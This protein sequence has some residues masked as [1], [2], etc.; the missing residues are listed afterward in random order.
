MSTNA[1]KA[2]G[3]MS[4]WWGLGLRGLTLAAAV[5][6]LVRGVHWHDMTDT[7]RQAGFLLPS[8]VI[9][10]NVG[11]MSLRALR[12]RILLER[13]LS[14][15]S[16]FVALL[17][18]SAINNITPFRGGNVARLWMLER[19]SGVTKSAAIAVTVVENL[20]EVSVLAAMGFAA[21]L[22]V[23]GQRWATLATPAVFAAAVALL[24]LLRFTAENAVDAVRAAYPTVRT[25]WRQRLHQFLLRTAPGFRALSQPGVPAR[26]L[27]LSLLAWTCETAMIVLVARAMGLQVSTPLA[28]VVLL[29]INLAMALPSTPASAGPFE[30]ATVAVLMLAGVGK[31]PALAFAL[32]YHAIQV[33]PVTVAGVAVLLL[34]KRRH[35]RFLPR[36]PALRP[37]GRPSSENARR[38][39]A[40]RGSSA[41]LR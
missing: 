39:Q 14:F 24:V 5:V 21:S 8:L 4:P 16:S 23:A 34:A 6:F 2:T 20:I 33:I 25:G 38:G 26:A 28:V 19:A 40:H 13:K 36:R 18:S 9:A 37:W 22:L 29:G 17:T 31:G 30:G 15:A 7:I 35:A 1:E 11:M 3:R 32:F 10:M 12:L 41:W 27:L